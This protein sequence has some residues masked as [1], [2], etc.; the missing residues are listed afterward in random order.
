MSHGDIMGTVKSSEPLSN[1]E[2]TSFKA[3]FI[4]VLFRLYIKG[5]QSM[6]LITEEDKMITSI[7]L[8][9]SSHKKCKEFITCIE[10]AEMI[11]ALNLRASSIDN[12]VLPVPVDPSITITG[13]F[14]NIISHLLVI[15]NSLVSL[16]FLPRF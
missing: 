16:D 9:L 6:M 4:V 11:S 10:S 8:F 13:I 7:I 1:D 15:H 5:P 2:L 3:H 12:F 14:L